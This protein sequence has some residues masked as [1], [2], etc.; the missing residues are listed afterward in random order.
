MNFRNYMTLAAIITWLAACGQ[1]EPVDNGGVLGVPSGAYA[2]DKSHTYVTFSYFHQGLSYP[3][4]RITGIDGELELDNSALENSTVS[5]AADVDSIRTNLDYFDKELASRK[6][7]HAD[8]YPHIT[9][10]THSYTPLNESVGELIGFVTIRDI[11]KPIVLS[12]VING[13]M[14]H[15]MLNKPVIGFSASGS[16]NRSDFGLDR[17]VPMVGDQVAISIEAEFLRGSTDASAAA[18]K[19]SAD[20]LSN[21]DPASL[22]VSADFGA[23]Q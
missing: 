17:F 20:A 7:F 23:E 1:G 5:I 4:L 12:V 2:V 19:I 6:F 13:A 10:S 9:L 16:L 22:Q 11:T 18:V 15:P 21:A 8:K 3:L 14:D